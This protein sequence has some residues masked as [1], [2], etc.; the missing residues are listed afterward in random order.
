MRHRSVMDTT[1]SSSR[2]LPSLRGCVAHVGVTQIYGSPVS[3]HIRHASF[4][5]LPAL[6]CWQSSGASKAAVP[7]LCKVQ[8]CRAA[9]RRAG[10]SELPRGVSHTQHT[11]V[12]ARWLRAA[13]AP[14]NHPQLCLSLSPP[15]SLPRPPPSSFAP[16]TSG[17]R[18]T[19]PKPRCPPTAHHACKS[20]SMFRNSHPAMPLASSPTLCR[21]CALKTGRVESPRR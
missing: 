8:P 7:V 1:V 3:C 19:P 17:R 2:I 9:R 5:L 14:P 6:Q 12:F 10:I 13:N 20:V 4:I 21:R 18:K 16:W 15:S 11:S